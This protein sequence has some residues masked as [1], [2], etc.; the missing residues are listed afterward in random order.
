MMVLPQQLETNKNGRDF[1]VGDLHGCYDK[2][3]GQLGRVNFDTECDR[4]FSVGDL[5][6]RGPDSVKCL[7][8][9]Q[10]PWFHAVQGNHDRMLM[11][12]VLGTW[13][14]HHSPVDLLRN[15]GGWVRDVDKSYLNYLTSLVADLPQL[16][17][18]PDF[19]VCH[20]QRTPITDLDLY[21]WDRDLAYAI[22]S[23]KYN[24]CVPIQETSELVQWTQ[25]EGDKVTFVGHNR[26]RK[27]NFLENHCMIDT[28]AYAEDG[29]LTLLETKEFVRCLK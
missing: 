27:I 5:A 17:E 18:T 28:N 20:A 26:T 2:L 12:F 9:L 29:H 25:Y 21:V 6:D 8:L 1:V 23:F 7:E 15:G 4:L 13:S 10:E 3:C 14:N 11:T 22:E 19:Y 24:D 16:I